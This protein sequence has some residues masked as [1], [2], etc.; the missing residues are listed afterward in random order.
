MCES[1]AF[2]AH[3]CAQAILSDLWYGGLREG[4]FVS[5]KVTLMLLGLAVP[6][7]YPFIAFCFASN[8]SKFLE[9]K[10]KE[11]LSAQPQTWEEHQDEIDTDSSSS[12]SSSSSST[13]SSTSSYGNGLVLSK[14]GN[15]ELN[16]MTNELLFFVL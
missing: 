2:I 5:A 3:P 11:E 13:S 7:L 16:T 12:S 4:R 9:F 6:P 1:K 14:N 8:S 15:A 10:T